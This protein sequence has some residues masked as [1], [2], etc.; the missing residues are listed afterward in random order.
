MGKIFDAFEK[1]K[2]ENILKRANKTLKKQ[3]WQALLRYNRATGKLD[4]FDRRIVTDMETPQR[5]LENKM[6]YP[7]GKLT[8]LGLSEV[9]KKIAHLKRLHSR[10]LTRSAANRN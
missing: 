4:M 10:R 9:K 7:D 5:L 3:D 2:K 1:Y 6:I 8:K